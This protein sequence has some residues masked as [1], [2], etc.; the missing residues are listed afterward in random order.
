M[1][2][3]R[4]NIWLAALFAYIEHYGGKRKWWPFDNGVTSA[5][6]TKA[7]FNLWSWANLYC[8]DNRNSFLDFFDLVGL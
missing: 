1:G 4:K 5:Q 7:T 8:V 3:K 2:K 6:R